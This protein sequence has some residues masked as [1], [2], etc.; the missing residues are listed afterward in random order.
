M[1]VPSAYAA[2]HDGYCQAGEICLW[3]G[4]SYLGCSDDYYED[5]ANYAGRTYASC[6][7]Q[8]LNDTVSSAFNEADWYDVD[9]Y[10]HS[11]YGGAS[12]KIDNGEGLT[13]L[14]VLG[15]NVSS[16]FW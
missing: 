14:G 1:I 4:G 3:E 15:N 13:S 9:I 10:E 2:S 11:N 16:H 8:N 5:I 7:S 12:R 6:G